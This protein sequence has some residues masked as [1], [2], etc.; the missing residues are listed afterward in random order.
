MRHLEAAFQEP[1]RRRIGLSD[2][3]EFIDVLAVAKRK[4]TI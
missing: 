2:N 3:N 1:V 4:Q